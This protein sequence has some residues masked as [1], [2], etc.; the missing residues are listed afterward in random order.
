MAAKKQLDDAGLDDAGLDDA[1]GSTSPGASANLGDAENAVARVRLTA[2]VRGQVQGVGFRWWTRCRGL[3]FGLTG[4]ASNLIDGRV[5]VIAQGSRQA[6]ER[7]L[8]VLSPTAPPPLNPRDRRPG[9][10]DHVT[11]RWSEAVDGLSGFV[12]R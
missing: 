11:H 2:W 6:A 9:R 8:A 1:G 3:E 4:S 5:E 10:V 7:L 12:E